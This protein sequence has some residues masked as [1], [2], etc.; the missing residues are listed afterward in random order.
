LLPFIRELSSTSQL[1]KNIKF[2]IYKIIIIVHVVLYVCG[3]WF[4]ILKDDHRLWIFENMVLRGIFGPKV[5][6]YFENGN[7]PSGSIKCW[8]VLE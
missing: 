8:E 1:H 4:L 3:T 6:D 5:E 2:T 7:E